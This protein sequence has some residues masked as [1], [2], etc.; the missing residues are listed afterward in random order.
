MRGKYILGSSEYDSFYLIKHS[1]YDL[2]QFN[3][4]VNLDYKSITAIKT[5]V[6]SGISVNFML[7]R[8]YNCI[9]A[10]DGNYR[11]VMRGWMR[12]TVVGRQL[13][14]EKR[15]CIIVKVVGV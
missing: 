3:A 2:L 7:D 12:V 14:R 11:L 10:L 6:D 8:L 5:L 1:I 9:I 4:S 15:H 13:K